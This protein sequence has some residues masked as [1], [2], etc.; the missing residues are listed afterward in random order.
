MRVTIPARRRDRAAGWHGV[1]RASYG[2]RDRRARSDARQQVAGHRRT[3]RLLHVLPRAAFRFRAG[4]S[5]TRHSRS[6]PTRPTPARHYHKNREHTASTRRRQQSLPELPRRHRRVGTNVVYGQVTTTGSM[7]TVRRIRHQSAVVA[8][9]QP[10]P[11]A[12][13]HRRPGGLTGLA[14]KNRGPTGAVKLIK[15]N[16]EC[17]SC[18][19]P[20]VQ[21]KDPVSQNFLVQDSS[22]GQMCLACHDPTRDAAARSISLPAGRSG[23]H[24]TAR[25]RSR[26]RP[27][28]A[29][30]A[31]WRRMP[32]SLA[33]RRTTPAA[34]RVC[35]AARTNRI[36]SRATTADRIFLR[37]RLCQCVRRVCRQG[38]PSISR[39]RPIL[40]MRPKACCSTT[41]VTRPASIATM[42][43]GSRTGRQLHSAAADPPL[44][45][46]TSPESAPPTAPR[47]YPAVNQY[48]NCLRCHGTSTGKQ[49]Q[50][51]Y[52]YFPVRAVSSGDP[53]NVI[54][55]FA[56]SSDFEPSGNAR[57]QQRARAT[58][59]ARQHV[60]S[61]WHHAGRAMGAQIFCTD[62]HN[63]DDNREF[64]GAGPNGPH[65]SRWTHILE[66]HYEFSQAAAPGQL[67]HQ[68]L[69]QSRSQRE[70]P[71]RVVRQVPRSRQPVVKNTSWSSARRHI[72]AGFM[73]RL[74][75]RP[76]HGRDKRQR[77]AASAW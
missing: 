35:C 4:A 18:H 16:I 63:S 39:R 12:E 48:E 73:F 33:T 42:D 51:I 6:R 52:G 30:I 61:G 77:S 71:V 45:E 8:S 69:S 22:S 56:I 26:R 47:Y 32:A 15:G 58:Q 27:A 49:V 3:C 9:L 11:A 24:S 28:S 7:T 70:R 2:R 65:G 29:A 23:M 59:P 43:I 60:E 37:C 62:C 19:D 34:R 36:A 20:H 72:N 31:R 55:Q 50:P 41:I 1:A 74:P 57:Q 21:A 10:G 38:R 75:H 66:R 44:A 67:D 5:G 64:G 13:G 14:G 53:L 54:P 68:S 25:T 76:R 40:T 46:R 17:T